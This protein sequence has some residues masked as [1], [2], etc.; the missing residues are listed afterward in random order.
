[1]KSRI[2]TQIDAVID[3]AK[4]AQ[5][6]GHGPDPD[7]RKSAEKELEEQKQKLMEMIKSI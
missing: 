6:E 5:E 4:T 1:M 7:Y 3:A 2:E